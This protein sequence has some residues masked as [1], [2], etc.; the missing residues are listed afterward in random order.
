[1][2]IACG[3][4]PFLFASGRQNNKIVSPGAT[5]FLT[6][7]TSLLPRKQAKSKL[8]EFTKTDYRKMTYTY[9]PKIL[10]CSSPFQSLTG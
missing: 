5:N 6:T 8:A 3:Q 1:M 4:S 7:K 2:G 10:A 9:S